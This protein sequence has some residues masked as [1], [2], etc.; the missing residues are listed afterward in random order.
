[1]T[2]ILY[3]ILGTTMPS[4]QQVNRYTDEAVCKQAVKELTDKNVRA[5]CL[6]K[7]ESK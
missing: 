1:M 4:L 6:P 2:Y 3:I 5:V 7:Q